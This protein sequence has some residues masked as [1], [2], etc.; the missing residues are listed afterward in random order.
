[1]RCF[2]VRTAV[3]LVLAGVLPWVAHRSSTA[4]SPRAFPREFETSFA[5]GRRDGQGR[6]MGGTEMRVLADHGGKPFAGNAPLDHS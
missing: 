5:A 6:F 1:M 4:G 3:L 2:R